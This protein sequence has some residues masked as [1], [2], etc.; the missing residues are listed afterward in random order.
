L[1]KQAKQ[2]DWFEL[3]LRFSKE[4]TPYQW[5][6]EVRKHPKWKMIKLCGFDGGYPTVSGFVSEATNELLAADVVI[7]DGDW[8]CM[9]G[10]TGMI[11]TFLNAKKDSMAVAFQKRA[12]VPGFHRS[13][14]KLY[15]QFPNRIQVVV[16]KDAGYFLPPPIVRR[17]KWLEVEFK[18]ERLEKPKDP[19]GDPGPYNKYLSVAMVGRIFQGDNTKV[20]AMN[21][22]RINI[23]LA[24]IETGES[25]FKKIPW[26]VYEAW[27]VK[28]NKNEKTLFHYARDR[29]REEKTTNP[30][31]G[32]EPTLKLVQQ[33]GTS[34]PGC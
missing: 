11:Y 3:A 7:W 22:G 21:G 19:D 12:E 10:W 17:H 26:T 4:L 18:A 13:Y 8:F 9:Q 5:A 28:Q 24:A 20:I 32:T 2:D 16:M 29:E 15:Q 33:E 14:W 30:T 1:L 31:K 27:R 6:K 25:P 23:A 34:A